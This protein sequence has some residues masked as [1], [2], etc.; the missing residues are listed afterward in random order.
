MKELHVLL[1]AATPAIPG[2]ENRALPDLTKKISDPATLLGNLV[3][4]LIGALLIMATLLALIQ[5]FQGGLEWISS[6]G[7]KTNLENARNRITNAIVGLVIVFAVWVVY[8]I[9]LQFLGIIG[10]G[11]A[12]KMKIPTLQ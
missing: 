2:V 10:E 12:V 1:A 7:D 6:G 3:A 8:I 5:L 4:G 9:I 11:G